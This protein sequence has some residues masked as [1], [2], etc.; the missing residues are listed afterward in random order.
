M[1]IAASYLNVVE[2]DLRRRGYRHRSWRRGALGSRVWMRESGPGV[3]TLRG[4]ELP[5]G[6]LDPGIIDRY[7]RKL[8]EFLEG[9]VKKQAISEIVFQG[10]GS[11][12]VPEWFRDWCTERQ[13]GIH[14][15]TAENA[16]GIVER[17]ATG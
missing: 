17:I 6:A 2:E 1:A 12:E 11:I 5:A 8:R 4:I 9:L 13:I 14:V 10:G 15:A 16:D 7:F 3:V